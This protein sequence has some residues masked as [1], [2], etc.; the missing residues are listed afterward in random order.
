MDKDKV[1]FEY[2]SEDKIKRIT[3]DDYD[4]FMWNYE[5]QT[6]LKHKIFEEYFDKF[7]KILGS[8]NN[9]NY[10]DGY[11]GCGVYYDIEDNNTYFGSPVLAGDVIQNKNPN[12]NVRIVII[13][14]N[15]DNIENLKKVF[16]HKNLESLNPIY[17]NGDF[18]KEINR[19]L[20]NYTLAPT[21][22]LVDPFG[23]S[24][25]YETLTK[26]LKTPK[27][28]LFF[29]FMFNS[30]QRFLQYEKVEERMKDLFGCDDFKDILHSSNREAE[31]MHLFTK[32]L[33]KIAKFAFPFRLQFP[34]KK[35]MTYYYMIHATNHVKGISIMKDCYAKYNDGK[36]EYFGA[37]KIKKLPL[38]QTDSYI[39]C[40]LDNFLLEKY[41]GQ[42]AT[43]LRIVEDCID[44][45]EYR[46][47]DLKE[48]IKRLNEAKQIKYIPIPQFTPKG[49]EKRKIDNEDL[50]SFYDEPMRQIICKQEQL[51]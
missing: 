12:K 46:E 50:I 32:Q 11:G 13:D 2:D 5:G 14:E 24:I 31:I 27:S 41:K 10:I 43:Y 23:F 39:E 48:A 25:K 29:N 35:D 47:K 40:E 26:I 30:I 49:K 34:N 7:V 22:F 19:I 21:F 4:F 8:N 51:F 16:R 28:E 38:F 1:H 37:D 9:I 15:S 20:D 44:S 33:K 6:K 36:V 3:Y 17:I 45:T 42:T 18:D